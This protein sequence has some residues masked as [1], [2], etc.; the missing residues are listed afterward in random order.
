MDTTTPQILAKGCARDSIVWSEARRYFYLRAKRRILEEAAITR[1]AAA[2]PSLSREDK[3][4]Y[5][6][7][8]IPAN[9]DL[10]S[11]A[12]V[13]DALEQ[14]ANDITATVRT[15]RTS[16]IAS[17]IASLATE[18]GAAFAEGLRAALGDKLDAE[19][20]AKLQQVLSQ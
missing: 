1:I 2:N 5:L 17:Q 4:A 18:D 9:V 8:V 11:D 19:T 14:A 16:A 7:Q 13:A 6:A 3:L 20:V 12:A 10:A 15:A